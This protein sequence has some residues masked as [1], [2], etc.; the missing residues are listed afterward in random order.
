MGRMTFLPHETGQR[1]PATR[2]DKFL[3]HPMAI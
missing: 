2:G 3:H 1:G